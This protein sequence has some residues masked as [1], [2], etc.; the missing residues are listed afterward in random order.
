MPTS[1]PIKEHRASTLELARKLKPIDVYHWIIEYGYFPESYVLPPCFRVAVRPGDP[2]AYFNLLNKAERPPET[3]PVRIHFPK[4]ELTD[5][6]FGI[7]DPRIHNDIAYNIYQNWKTRLILP[8][9]L[10]SVNG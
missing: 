9:V 2:K 5:R 3:E 10:E 4:T 1:N 7:I 8:V 6:T